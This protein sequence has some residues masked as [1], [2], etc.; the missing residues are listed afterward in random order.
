MLVY[1]KY[2]STASATKSVH[3][4]KTEI[5]LSSDYLPV[6]YRVVFL[7]WRRWEFL[8]YRTTLV[9]LFLHILYYSP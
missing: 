7:G 5:T 1:S 4:L 3:N 9:Y 6:L 2:K 8:S